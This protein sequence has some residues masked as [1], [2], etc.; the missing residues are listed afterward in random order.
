MLVTP[1][2]HEEFFFLESQ[3]AILSA[4]LGKRGRLFSAFLSKVEFHANCLLTLMGW[5]MERP[6]SSPRQQHVEVEELEALLNRLYDK[7]DIYRYV[8][9][10]YFVYGLKLAGVEEPRAFDIYL[11]QVIIQMKT[12]L[13][14]V[15][16]HL[17][18]PRAGRPVKHAESGLIHGVVKAYIEFFGELP[19]KSRDASF[20]Q[21]ILQVFEYL[22]HPQADCSR[23]IGRI[24]EHEMAQL[25]ES[26]RHNSSK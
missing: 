6:P 10:V 23:L 14:I 7:I 22:D 21:F 8:W 26:P 13:T 11:R 16:Q 15:R 24:V 20:H 4:I 2:G 3:R 17:P 18:E 19:P 1:D 25:E 5:Q 9:V 12:A